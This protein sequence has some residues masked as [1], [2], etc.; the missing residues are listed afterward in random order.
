MLGFSASRIVDVKEPTFVQGDDDTPDEVT[1][2][3]DVRVSSDRLACSTGSRPSDGELDRSFRFGGLPQNESSPEDTKQLTLSDIIPPPECAR[4]ISEASLLLD[5]LED[6]VDDSVLKSIY[7]KLMGKN[8]TD[9]TWSDVNSSFFECGNNPISTFR[10]VSRPTSGV[11]FAGLESFEEVRRRFEFSGDCSFYPPPARNSRAPHCREDSAFSIAS[12]SSYGRVLNN[13]VSDPF[14]YGLPSLRERPSSL[15]L[16]S[17]SMSLTV[18]D[19]FAFIR[20]QPR[21]RVDSDASSFYFHAPACGHGRRESNTSV[22]SQVPPISLY[23]RNFG[24]CRNNSTSSSIAQSYVRHGAN[25]GFSAWARH[26]KDPSVDSLM[27]DFSAVHPARPGLGDKMFEG[28]SDHG[29]LTS[30]SASPPENTDVSQNLISHHTSFNSKLDDDQRSSMDDS[31]FEKTG[32]RSSM[33]SDSVFG[34]DLSHPYQGGPLPP[35]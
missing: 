4:A 5:N 12:V 16:S 31:P 8:L 28:V 13:G 33:S 15:D 9:N 2:S 23:N 14:D 6:S 7:A 27:S 32:Q 3:D 21:T 18:D 29:P 19:T 34:D 10:G 17:I 25:S 26:R 1:N 11:S 24:H 30:I 20:G 35:N 22:S